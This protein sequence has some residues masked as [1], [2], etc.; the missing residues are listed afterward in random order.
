[1]TQ[2]TTQH[3]RFVI[4]RHFDA[5]LALVYAAWSTPEGKSRW[6]GGSSEWKPEKREFDLRVG[7]HERLAGRWADGSFSDFQATYHDIVPQQRLVYAYSMYVDERLLSVSL[8]TVELRAEG[9]GTHLTYT[10][11]VAFL[12]GLDNVASREGGTKQLFEQLAAALKSAST[13]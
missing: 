4:D 11:Q 9:K 13:N 3:E 7:G 5:P 8:S 2:S 10:E 6:F 12:D 1:M